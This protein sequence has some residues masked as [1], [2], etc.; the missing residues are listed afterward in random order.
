M[1]FK[2]HTF[3]V[4]FAPVPKTWFL[5]ML[6]GPDSFRPSCSVRLWPFVFHYHGP[7]RPGKRR[8]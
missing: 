8:S 5:F 1:V 2:G 6:A 7:I 3:E 4:S